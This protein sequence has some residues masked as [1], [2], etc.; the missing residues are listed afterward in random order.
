VKKRIRK[1]TGNQ[2]KGGVA[3]SQ[4]RDHMAQIG[5]KGGIAVSANREHMVSIGRLGGLATQ[6]MLDKKY[7]EAKQ[8]HE[9]L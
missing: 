8:T 4:N 3:V 9:V 1:G 6:E 5:R 7:L 2:W